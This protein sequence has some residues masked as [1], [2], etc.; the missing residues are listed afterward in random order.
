MSPGAQVEVS[1]QT[2]QYQLRVRNPDKKFTFS[3]ENGYLAALRHFFLNL[4][5]K[6]GEDDAKKAV[7]KESK[8]KGTLKVQRR[9]LPIIKHDVLNQERNFQ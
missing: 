8:R 6:G 5:F 1:Q 3:P 9:G 7:V 4:P 2:Q